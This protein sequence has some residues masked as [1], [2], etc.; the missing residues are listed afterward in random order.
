VHNDVRAVRV[1][2]RLG[3]AMF[4]LEVVHVDL[5]FFED[6]DIVRALYRA[7]QRGVTIDLIVRDTCRLR[8]GLDGVSSTIKVV[9]IIG[10]FLEHERI[11]YFHNAGRPEY[12]IGSA[13]AMQRNLEKRVEVLVPIEDPRLQAELRHILDTQLTDQ[14]GA[15]DML[16]DG[17]YVQRSGMGAKHCQQQ[18]IERTERRLKEATRL[19]RRKVQSTMR[20]KR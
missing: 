5:Y 17:S 14:R 19:R 4:T 9:S 10:R 13:D 7:S 18:A 3:S 2:P 6:V 12:Y 11:Y 20:R 1:Q 8:P 15:W 16:S